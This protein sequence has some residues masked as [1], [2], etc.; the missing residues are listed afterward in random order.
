MFP[1][2]GWAVAQGNVEQKQKNKMP[3]IPV[4]DS[5]QP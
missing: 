1:L 2:F 4:I 5:L 3:K